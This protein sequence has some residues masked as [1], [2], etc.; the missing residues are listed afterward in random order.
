MYS[1]H[2]ITAIVDRQQSTLLR[3]LPDAEALADGTR[4][5]KEYLGSMVYRLRG[6]IR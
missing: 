4:A 1:I 6:W 3:W 5:L 2:L